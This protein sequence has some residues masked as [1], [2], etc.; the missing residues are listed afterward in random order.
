MTKRQILT[1]LVMATAMLAQAEDGSQL[2][3]RY[4]ETN[5]MYSIF[6]TAQYVKGEEFLLMN[7]DVYYDTNI[8]EGMLQGENQSKIAGH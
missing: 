8:I 3:L 7:S 4:A 6:L 2:W 5:N 1:L